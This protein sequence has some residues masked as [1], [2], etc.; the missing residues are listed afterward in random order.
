MRLWIQ[1]IIVNWP[2]A[3]KQQDK[4]IEAAGEGLRM[5]AQS[6]P[7]STTCSYVAKLV[8]LVR[9]KACLAL[10]QYDEAMNMAV[11]AQSEDLVLQ[12]QGGPAG[13]GRTE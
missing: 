4:V 13:R 10:K 3:A 5:L 9:G 7:E 12:I 8:G 1:S 2:V 6:L 11:L